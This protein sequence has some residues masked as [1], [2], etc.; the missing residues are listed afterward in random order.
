MADIDP[1]IELMARL[2]DPDGG[3][4]WD[5]EQ[6]FASIA[7]YT[8]EEA[9]EVADAIE[10]GDLDELRGELGDLLFQVAFHARM[11]QE[12]GAF[13]FGDVIATI[14]EK[15]ERRHPHVFGDAEMLTADEQTTRWEAQKAAERETA[16]ENRASALDGIARALP[17]LVRA[18]KLQRR[19]A[20][21]GFDW[22]EIGPVFDKIA[23][24][25]GEV[26]EELDGGADR[27]RVTAEIGDL[28]FSCVNLARHAGVDPEMA[29]RGANERFSSRF[30]HVETAFSEREQEMDQVS[31][32]ELDAEWERAKRIERDASFTG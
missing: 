15:M 9:Y 13:T 4:P 23:E 27:H 16:G 8:I 31:L 6:S 14:V 10:H 3:C 29:L 19:A 32:E 18:D 17:A 30:R 26:R 21:V 22:P 1:L 5:L 20:R 24:E 11:A 28:L 25:V 2:R 12:Q 7:P